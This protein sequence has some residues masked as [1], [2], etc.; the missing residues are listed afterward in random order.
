MC[1]PSPLRV[2]TPA[3]RENLRSGLRFAVFRGG[4]AVARGFRFFFTKQATQ[5]SSTTMRQASP[6]PLNGI[7]PP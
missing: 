4:V 5:E 6:P 2:S 3:V 7:S 1:G